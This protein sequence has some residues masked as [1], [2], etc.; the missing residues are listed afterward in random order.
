MIKRTYL[1]IENDL[2]NL[3]ICLYFNV[4]IYSQVIRTS[5]K[6]KVQLITHSDI[7]DFKLWRN[8]YCKK[9]CNSVETSNRSVPRKKK[10]YFDASFFHHYFHK[11]GM[12]TSNKNINSFNKRDFSLTL[13]TT[14]SYPHRTANEKI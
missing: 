8:K 3:N 12:V 1:V 9:T 5:S 4:I 2:Q 13:D 10:V 14:Q 7:L 11:K 6:F